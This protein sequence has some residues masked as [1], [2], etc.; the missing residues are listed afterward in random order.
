VYLNCYTI[1]DDVMEIWLRFINTRQPVVIEGYAD[2]MYA[3]SRRILEEQLQ[4][5]R[6]RGIITS[7]GVLLPT[8]M[9][10]ISAAFG[11]CPVLNRYGSREV[12]DVACS[13]LASRSLH[14][15]ELLYH[16]EIVDEN[17]R[18]CPPGVEGD[19]LVTLLTN[20]T[21][22]LIRYRIEDRGIWDEGLCSCGRTT[23]RIAAITGRQS[24]YLLAA[25]GSRVNGTAL[26]TL[27]YDVPG[28]RRFQYRQTHPDRVK[29][30]VVPLDARSQEQL[31]KDLPV[32]VKRLAGL[33]RGS[34]VEVVF[35]DEIV[36]SASGKHRY[37]INEIASTTNPTAH[38]QH[39]R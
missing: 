13:C 35:V 24:D 26:T 33:L 6:P 21:M 16:I 7:A 20:F 14:V 1:S 39:A 30:S 5:H 31:S 36:P 37:I 4:M 22:P 32:R 15:S 28:I 23:R 17:E 19:I 27:L 34:T 38:H 11:R 25:N 18:E 10:T 29:L 2:A 9:D 3:L 12:G 8:M